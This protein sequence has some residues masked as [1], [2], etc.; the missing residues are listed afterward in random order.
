M[1]AIVISGISLPHM[2]INQMKVYRKTEYRYFNQGVRPLFVFFR[3]E[4]PITVLPIYNNFFDVTIT[5]RS[6]SDIPRPY[7]Y[8]VNKKN[9]K[10]NTW[11]IYDQ[12]SI[13]YDSKQS[14]KLLQKP[15]DIVW[16]VS[17]CDTRSFRE[18]YVKL[19]KKANSFLKID[20]FGKCGNNTIPKSNQK[21]F[22][23]LLNQ[24]KFHLSFENA[25]CSGYVTEKLFNPLLSDT[26]P[27]GKY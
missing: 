23:K 26:I 13:K 18:N 8:L 15:K 14:F 24:Y 12:H 6:D 2:E 10:V 21:D 1:D 27:I 20:I 9:T 5:F 17:H 22:M 4:P 3:M 16:F 11:K 19:M 7:G 25:Q